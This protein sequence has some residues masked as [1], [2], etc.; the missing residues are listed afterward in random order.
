MVC[1]HGFYDYYMSQVPF[2]V[3]LYPRDLEFSSVVLNVAVL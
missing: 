1:E 3:F 2:N